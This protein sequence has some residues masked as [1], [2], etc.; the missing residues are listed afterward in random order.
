[1]DLSFTEEQEALRDLARKILEA[2]VTPARLREVEAG[3]ERF[4]RALWAELAR[5]G[6]LGI[7]VPQEHDGSGG[8]ILE[9]C[10][11]LEEV[12]RT[13]APVPVWPALVLGALPVVAFGTD[14]QRGRLLPGVA[15]G[16]VILTSALAEPEEED[17]APVLVSASR[18][19]SSWLLDGTV[20]MVPAAHVAAGVLVP[21]RTA[22]G[23]T[24]IFL[25]DPGGSGV[26]LVRQEATGG[27]PRFELTLSGADGESLAAPGTD[28]AAA[29]WIS[30]RATVGLCA[31]QVGLAER[32][33]HLTAEYTTGREQFGR[34]LASFQAVQQRA[35]DS[36]IDVEA[37][38]WTMWE[39]AW[40]LSEG[41]PAA[42]HVAVAKFWAAE[43]GQRV[44]AAAQ[45]LHGGI[46]VDVE[47]PLY[48]YTRW[49]KLVEL[50]LGGANRHLARLGA[51]MRKG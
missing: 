46:G 3:P 30:E 42:E 29:T 38:R 23:H 48:R 1:M 17:P 6:L 41:L 15:R 7:T 25:V 8:G 45:H 22:E 21:A 28:P 50:T 14:E 47:Y 39:A 20:S 12:G 35:A 24:G 49:S 31:L 13:V 16:D 40:R 11:L 10:L 9:A 26:S 32:A 44:L 51:E 4:D 27:E 36:Y 34:P 2:E 19:G 5:A 37:M 18:D 43:A 33:L